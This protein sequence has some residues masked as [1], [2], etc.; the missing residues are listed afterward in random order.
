M[1][2]IQT[3]V[4]FEV[5]KKKEVNFKTFNWQIGWNHRTSNSFAD[6]MAMESLSLSSAFL[7]YVCNIDSIPRLF[8]DIAFADCM[9]GFGV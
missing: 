5:I 3:R 2:I 9:S 7:F 1:A 4:N 6:S 8:L